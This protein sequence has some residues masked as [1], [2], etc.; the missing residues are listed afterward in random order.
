M[1]MHKKAIA[2]LI[3]TLIM[4]LFAILLGAVVISWGSSYTA[5]GIK[6][7]SKVSVG[8]AKISGESQAC[9]ADG[10]VEY[11]IENDGASAIDGFKA[12]VI[13]DT[14]YNIDVDMMLASGDVAKGSFGYSD[15]ASPKALR[16]VPMTADG[17]CASGA[18]TVDLNPCMEISIE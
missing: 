13:G 8:I 16:I 7:C 12:F 15:V 9:Y 10:R 17:L 5:K 2:P 1:N 11:I 14:I 18:L 6:E 4:L 3:S